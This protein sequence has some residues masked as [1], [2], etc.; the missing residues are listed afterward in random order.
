MISPYP[1]GQIGV[2]IIQPGLECFRV[3]CMAKKFGRHHGASRCVMPAVGA[4]RIRNAAGHVAFPGQVGPVLSKRP[5]QA[6]VG[7]WVHPGVRAVIE[8]MQPV[9][10]RMRYGIVVGE[11][12]I[13]RIFRQKG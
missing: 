7:G 13:I 10:M 4:I 1:Y 2:N 9:F 5:S 8:Y 6:D 12:Y 11:Q 3:G